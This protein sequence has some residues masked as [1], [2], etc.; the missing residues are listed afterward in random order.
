MRKL[1]FTLCLIGQTTYAQVIFKAKDHCPGQSLSPDYIGECNSI[2]EDSQS[3]S[4]IANA[5]SETSSKYLSKALIK[6]TLIIDSSKCQIFGGELD[7][8]LVSQTTNST[9]PVEKI[10][11]I[12]TYFSAENS[13][14]FSLWFNESRNLFP[15]I[16]KDCEIE[17]VGNVSHIDISSLRLITEILKDSTQDFLDI[18]ESIETADILNESWI[19][20]Q[21][22]PKTLIDEADIWDL[23]ADFAE[24][25]LEDLLESENLTDFEAERVELLQGEGG[26]ID[27]Y[28]NE[29][30]KNRELSVKVESALRGV[31]NCETGTNTFCIRAIEKAREI[32]KEKYT[33]AKAEISLVADFIDD[34]IRRLDSYEDTESSRMRRNLERLKRT[35]DNS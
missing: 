30:R 25:E 20:V 31:S 9:L 29:A 7:F 13:P 28:R 8:R 19:L 5:I 1:I 14:S 32:T 27:N 4:F 2:T 33:D 22:M 17:V 10:E 18:Y 23:E 3:E 35:L 6:N 12:E 16:S 24:S 26:I 21:N 34:E 15:I 11:T